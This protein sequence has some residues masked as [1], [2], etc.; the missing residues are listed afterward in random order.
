MH[1]QTKF[2]VVTPFSEDRTK[3]RNHRAFTLIELLVVIAIIAILASMLLPSLAR[4]K[5][6]AK[7]TYCVSNVKQLALAMMMYVDDN[8]NSYPPR[9][10]DPAAGSPYPCKPC[11]T[12]DWRPYPIRYLGGEVRVVGGVTNVV[13]TTN[14]F[15]CPSDKG[16]P[17]DIA[18]DPI[19]Q[20]N[21]V[22][23]RMA[24][25]YGSSFC[26]NVVMTRL[27]KESAI[28]IP[29]ETFMGAEI[30]SWHQPLA[31]ND[32]KG[33]TRKPVRMAY[34]CDGHAAVT[35]EKTIQEQCAP[36]SAPGIGPV[37]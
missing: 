12:V 30:W 24:D 9:M 21:P 25:F 6:K 17:A 20:T 8:D 1:P 32:F 27:G 37:P 22:P 16:L 34:F 10:P 26:L 29:S 2:S 31:I 23:K 35:S 11:R 28:P 13:G 18:A 7:R 33:A 5:E 3:R 14:V 19:N 36:P 4:A 15:A